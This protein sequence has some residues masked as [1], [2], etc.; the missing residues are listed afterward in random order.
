PTSANA[1]ST[2]RA[3]RSHSSGG[4]CRGS[5]TERIATRSASSRRTCC[6][7]SVI[8][9]RMSVSLTGTDRHVAGPQ[10]FG[11]LPELFELVGAVDLHDQ[12]LAADRGA[13][14]DHRS[15]PRARGAV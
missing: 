9:R 14:R 13:V 15:G 3:A 2:Q 5:A 6:I 4:Y 10:P 11:E 12:Q 1:A 8:L 7:W